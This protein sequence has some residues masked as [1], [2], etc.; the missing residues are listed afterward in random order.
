MHLRSPSALPSLFRRRRLLARPPHPLH[1]TLLL[2][3]CGR[4]CVCA[5]HWLRLLLRRSRRTGCLLRKVRR[6][7]PGAKVKKHTAAARVAWRTKEKEETR[8]QNRERG[9]RT[10]AVRVAVH[11]DARCAYSC[12]SL[13]CT[14][15]LRQTRTPIGTSARCCEWLAWLVFLLPP[16]LPCLFLTHSPYSCPR[17]PS[18]QVSKKKKELIF[19]LFSIL[20]LLLI[21]LFGFCDY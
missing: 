1:G 18:A 20:T 9:L 13:P 17:T 16:P 2:R 10:P 11:K 3:A 8:W 6:A 5:V 4:G 15:L 7:D 21:Q 19:P 12:A 14:A